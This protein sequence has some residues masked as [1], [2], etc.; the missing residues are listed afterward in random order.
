MQR[1]QSPLMSTPR[2]APSP[3]SCVLPPTPSLP[4][5]KPAQVEP[6]AGSQR[7]PSSLWAHRNL[8]P[9]SLRILESNNP[10]SHPVKPPRQASF[11][12]Y[13]ATLYFSS[14]LSLSARSH[15]P[16]FP[17]PLPLIF[18]STNSF[19][20]PSSAPISRFLRS[21]ASSVSSVSQVQ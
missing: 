16:S 10:P 11:L 2:D 21:L 9:A 5:N 18:P 8:P 3:Q 19:T 4:H 6:C 14:F 20:S 13:A 7:H 1:F 17:S 15:H 12:I